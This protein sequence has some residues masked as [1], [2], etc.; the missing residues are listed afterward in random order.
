M[1]TPERDLDA[2]A[3]ALAL[4]QGDYGIV[5]AKGHI[6]GADGQTWLIQVVGKRAEATLSAQSD[7][8]GL[9]C[10]GKRG[11]LDR[12]GIEALVA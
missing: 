8:I 11:T 4:G 6:R 9:V 7:R 3:L 10:I 2:V 12:A 1:L 5:R